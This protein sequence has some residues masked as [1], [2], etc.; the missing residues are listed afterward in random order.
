MSVSKILPFNY[1][2]HFAGHWQT[3]SV[4]LEVFATESYKDALRQASIMCMC[5][6]D[7]V[8]KFIGITHELQWIIIE[9]F[10]SN[11][12]SEMLSTDAKDVFNISKVLDIAA[13]VNKHCLN[14]LYVFKMIYAVLMSAN[15]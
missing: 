5:D 1:S 13:Q 12:L 6:H 14:A 15:N 4:L 2:Y 7:N 3:Q 10:S 11:N 8:V 9:W